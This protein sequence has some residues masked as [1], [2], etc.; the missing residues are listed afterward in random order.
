MSTANGLKKS[1][2]IYT[3]LNCLRVVKCDK[4]NRIP[5]GIHFKTIYSIA[6]SQAVMGTLL[7]ITDAVQVKHNLKSQSNIASLTPQPAASCFA[8]GVL[9][10]HG[11]VPSVTEVQASFYDSV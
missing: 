7:Y 3:H 4:G 1:T 8:S 9:K 11:K 10:I 5:L 2:V 6:P